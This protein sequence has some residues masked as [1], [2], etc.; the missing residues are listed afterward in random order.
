MNYD[1]SGLVL[2]SS[3]IHKWV[4]QVR[5]SECRMINVISVDICRDTVESGGGMTHSI[6][7]GKKRLINEVTFELNSWKMKKLSQVE[8]GEG[9][10]KIA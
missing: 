3:N 6:W 8:S 1:M 4:R 5:K 2:D 9:E 10:L 7:V